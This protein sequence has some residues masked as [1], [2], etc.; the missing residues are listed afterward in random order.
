MRHA[1]MKQHGTI[2]LVC[3]FSV[4]DQL[5]MNAYRIV[6]GKPKGKRPTERS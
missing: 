4:V 1:M 5:M 6:M 3:L 2:V